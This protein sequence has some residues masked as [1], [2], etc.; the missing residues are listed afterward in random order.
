VA[1][2]KGS[3]SWP[4]PCCSALACCATLS[5]A[6]AVEGSR[7]IRWSHVPATRARWRSLSERIPGNARGAEG[8][9]VGGAVR[10]GIRLHQPG[11]APRANAGR[12]SG[13]PRGVRSQLPQGDRHASL[14]GERGV[15]ELAGGLEIELGFEVVGGSL[16]VSVIPFTVMAILPTNK[17]LLDPATANDVDLAERLLSRWGRLHAV[18]SVLSLAALL[19]FLFL[20]GRRKG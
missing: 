3:R 8:H 10:R 7:A 2:E 19:L 20:L 1:A 15:L 11:G 12:D 16:F 13:R 5:Y 4:P 14:F 18:R 9:A 17:R 6:E